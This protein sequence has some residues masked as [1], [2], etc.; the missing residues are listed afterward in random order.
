M[1][2]WIT[3]NTKNPTISAS[4]H[5]IAT[6]TSPSAQPT[7]AHIAS[8]THNMIRWDHCPVCA[9]VTGS[10]GSGELVT[11]IGIAGGCWMVL[12]GSAIGGTT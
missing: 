1:K 5:P 8:H 9:G 11:G 10:S 3:V 4:S 7:R 12:V 6:S 2:P